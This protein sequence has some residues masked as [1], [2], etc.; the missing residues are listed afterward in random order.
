MSESGESGQGSLLTVDELAARVG[1]TVRTTR[2]YATLG[3]MPPPIRK[4]RIAYYDEGH[5]ARLE[6]VRALQEHGFTLQAIEGYMSTLRPDTTVEELVLQRAMLVPWSP[7]AHEELSRAQLEERAGR[8]L[9]SKEINHLVDMRAVERSGRSFV[10]QP[11]LR[12]AL[13]LLELDIP[14]EGMVAAGDAIHEHMAA[15]AHDLTEVMRS[16]VVQPFRKEQHSADEARAFEATI[17]RLRQLT[18][19]AMVIEFQRSAN[20]MIAGSLARSRG[21]AGDTA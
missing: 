8:R 5:R 6:M 16:Q 12:V 2:Y 11:S 15:L 19:E 7:L 17:A 3:L 4:G 10:P 18:V 14:V 21:E 1:M 20:K 13:D 9:S